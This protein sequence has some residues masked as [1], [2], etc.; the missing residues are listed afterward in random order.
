M[1]LFLL[2]SRELPE[3]EELIISHLPRCVC[4]LPCPPIPISPTA[5]PCCHPLCSCP[6]LTHATVLP[7]RCSRSPT[8]GTFRLW[9]AGGQEWTLIPI[10]YTE[11]LLS[12]RPLKWLVGVR[13]RRAS[14][15]D[16]NGKSIG[17]RVAPYSL[18][19]PAHPIQISRPT[20]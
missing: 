20:I 6:H 11:G 4:H 19:I 10:E 12:S 8:C 13:V 5:E 7:R 17:P 15:Q 16:W 1:R 14:S 9:R 2:L 3:S 18:D